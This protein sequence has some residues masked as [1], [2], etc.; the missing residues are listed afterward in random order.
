MDSAFAAWIRRPR[1]RSGA[2]STLLCFPHAGGAASF[3]RP[4]AGFLDP[5]IEQWTVQY[6][7][8]EDRAGEAQATR[9]DELVDGTLG[10]IAGHLDRPV[11]LFGHSMGA[12]VAHGV[13]RALEHR[14]VPVETLFVSANGPLGTRAD[15]AAH[16]LDD[17]GLL[18]HLRALGGT[19]TEVFDHPEL[20][21]RVLPIIRGDYRLLATAREGWNPLP[22]L[23][24][25]IVAF[26]AADDMLAPPA[27]LSRWARFTTGGFRRRIFPGG[28]FYLA[29]EFRVLAADM[30]R[31]LLANTTLARG[32]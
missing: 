26:G 16:L 14:G 10:A 2:V 8:R 20:V 21:A 17:D 30:S 18:A 5:S 32:A 22:A 6:P 28:H 29:E 7:A 25:P 19:Q 4:L 12:T 1:P 23:Y 31:Q 3:Y 24:A 13:A 9:L 11:A 27:D 15:A